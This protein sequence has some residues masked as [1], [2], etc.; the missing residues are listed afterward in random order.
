MG[1]ADRVEAYYDALREGEP[2]APFFAPVDGAVKVGISER[3]VGGDAVA[4]GLREQTERTTDWSVGS[5]DLRVTERDRHA[6]FGDR[7]SLAWTDTERRIRYEFDTRWTGTLELRGADGS[8]ADGA[9]GA[10][11]D[12][13][14]AADGNGDRWQFVS[15]H[16]STARAL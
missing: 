16:V 12:G 7:V 4:E 1:A 2:L 10:G 13:A 15:M 5:R 6:W 9:D 11:E 8:S 14:T 3:L